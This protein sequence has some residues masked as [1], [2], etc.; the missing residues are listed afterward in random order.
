MNSLQKSLYFFSVQSRERPCALIRE[1]LFTTD[2]L[3]QK[4]LIFRF[5]YTQM[6]AA[7]WREMLKFL[8]ENVV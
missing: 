3:I 8:V 7:L 2:Q 5:N 4:K 6:C 1:R